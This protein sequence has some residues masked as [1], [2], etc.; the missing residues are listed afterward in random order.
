M[1]AFESSARDAGFVSAA[2]FAGAFFSSNVWGVLSDVFGRRP[3]CLSSPL[4]LFLSVCLS[5]CMCV[6][7][8][9]CLSVCLSASLSVSICLSVLGSVYLSI[10]VHFVS[11]C[12]FVFATTLSVL[13]GDIITR[14]RSW[15]ITLFQSMGYSSFF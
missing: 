8:S 7:L 2:Y 6:C 4:S 1:F 11:Q 10:N 5:V 15:S 9:A 14:Q 12:T 13:T 3:V